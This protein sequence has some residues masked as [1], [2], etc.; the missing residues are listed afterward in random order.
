[1]PAREHEVRA[2]AI[3]ASFTD[4]KTGRSMALDRLR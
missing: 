1:M 2:E 3:P 4:P